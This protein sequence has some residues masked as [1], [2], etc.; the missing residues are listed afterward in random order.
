MRAAVVHAFDRPLAIEEIPTPVPDSGQVLVRI[1]AAGLCHT[2]I[3]AARGEWPVKPTPPFV[4]GHEGVGT[5]VELGPGETHGLA[6]GMRV[7]LPWLGYACG[8]CRW[9]NSGRE[10]LC[11]DQLNT[12]YSINGGFAE[13][14]VGYARHVV[15]VPEGIDPIDAAPLTCAG[16]TTYKAVKESGARA[17][18]VVAVFGAGGLGHL[19]IQYARITGA[20]VV[21]VDVNPA[22]LRNAQAVGAAHV[23]DASQQDP[24]AAIQRLGGADVAIATAVNPLAFE[25]ALRSLARGGRLVC[26]GLPAHNEMQLPIFE[27]VL[28][29]L[30]VKGS[31]VGTHHDLEEVFALHRRGL[32]RVEHAERELEEV[33]D[34]IEQVLDGSAESPRLVFR[35]QPGADSPPVS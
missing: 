13:Y 18:D 20:E 12:G 33:N 16:V 2:D 28:G 15:A 27:T 8:S 23:V 1:E 14:A 7:A 4:P 17:A 34:A 21:A 29:G 22:R 31:I 30:T 26:V 6:T 35:M 19:A 24:V 5:I 9:C 11:P 32:T 25:Q 10:T 3:H